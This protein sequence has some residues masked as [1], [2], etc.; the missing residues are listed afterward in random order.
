YGPAFQGLRAVWR[1]GA[2]VFAEVRLPEQ[3]DDAVAYGIH[4]ALLDAALH[5]IGSGVLDSAD[6][7]WVPFSWQGVGLSATGASVLRVRLTR[8][9]ENTVALDLADGAG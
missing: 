8:T 3:A 7:A 9:S 5:P 4:P 2:E 6:G 1:R